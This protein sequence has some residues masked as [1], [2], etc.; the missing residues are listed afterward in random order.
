MHV[1]HIQQDFLRVD[2]RVQ[3]HR[4]KADLTPVVQAALILKVSD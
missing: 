4:V 2:Q 3:T 1:P